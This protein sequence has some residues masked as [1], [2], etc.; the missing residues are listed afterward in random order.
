LW[1]VPAFFLNDSEFEK[2][3]NGVV[4]AD[5]ED[6]VSELRRWFIE[7]ISQHIADGEWEASAFDDIS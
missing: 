2:R 1:H 6:A 3:V 5:S 4:C 7:S